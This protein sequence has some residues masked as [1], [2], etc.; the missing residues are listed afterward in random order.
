MTH[1]SRCRVVKGVTN[2]CTSVRTCQAAITFPVIPYRHQTSVA[3]A[4]L[5]T[6]SCQW[7]TRV[8]VTAVTAEVTVG[9]R[10]EVATGN[11][12]HPA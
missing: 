1:Q 12:G 7:V 2:V 8:V 3:P 10:T 11:D 4:R 9:S 6:L 5:R